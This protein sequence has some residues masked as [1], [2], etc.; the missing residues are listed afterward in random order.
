M[1]RLAL[2]ALIAAGIAVG[3]CGG[4]DSA[5]DR[6]DQRKAPPVTE[7]AGSAKRPK[8]TVPPGPPPKNLVVRDL[9]EG[10]GAVAR[11]GQRLGVQYV[12][13]NYRTGEEFEVFWGKSGPFHFAFGT[14]E[15]RKGWDIGLKGMKVGGRRELILPSRLAYG[16]GPLLYVV[17]LVSIE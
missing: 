4:S 14:G 17:E 7:I 6:S 16:T 2:P 1:R 5:A 11:H 8:V 13:V 9:K 15:V 12:G 10:F 3:A